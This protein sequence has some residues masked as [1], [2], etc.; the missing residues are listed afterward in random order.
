[1]NSNEI[2]KKLP[3]IIGLVALW[4]I[5]FIL[6]LILIALLLGMP[7]LTL[8]LLIIGA[9]ITLISNP[10][11][12]GIINPVMNI[13][14]SLVGLGQ[15][16]NDNSPPILEILGLLWKFFIVIIFLKINSRFNIVKN[17]LLKL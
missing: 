5:L 7:S 13:I 3:T 4:E 16:Y 11:Q 8:P 9:I 2:K 15:F 10:L 12:T 14:F 6:V 1:M 17:E